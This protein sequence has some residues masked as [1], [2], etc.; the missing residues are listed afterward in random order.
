MALYDG[1][2]IFK[3]IN[4]TFEE[5]VLAGLY[6]GL[7]LYLNPIFFFFY[8]KIFIFFLKNQLL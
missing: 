8:I 3:S 1:L 4:A 5:L 7:A 2:A 6:D